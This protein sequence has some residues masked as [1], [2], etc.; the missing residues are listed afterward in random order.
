MRNE[1]VASAHT[2]ALDG[3]LIRDYETPSFSA[4]ATAPWFCFYHE[5]WLIYSSS[6]L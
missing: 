4:T 2:Y 5:V 3:M 6:A 1:G